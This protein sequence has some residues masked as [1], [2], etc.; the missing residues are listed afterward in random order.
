MSDVGWAAYIVAALLALLFFFFSKRRFDLLTVAYI[1]AIF[2]FLPLLWGRVSQSSRDLTSIVEPEVYVIATLYLLAL[3]FAA[4]LLR[5]IGDAPPGAQPAICLSGWYL[6]LAIVGIVGAFVAS[7]EALIN[8]DK[9]QALKQVGFFYVLF[10]VAASL[11]CISSVVERRWWL[12]A[13]A[14]CLLAIDLL[15]GF[16]VFVTLTALSV[17]LVLLTHLG[18]IRLFKKVPSYGLAA[19]ALV[20]SMLLVHSVR[21]VILG[22]TATKSSEMRGD[23]VQFEDP[24]ADGASH[25]TISTSHSTISKWMSIPLRLLQQSEPFIIQATLVGVVQTDLS[26]RASNIFKS[27]FLLLPP[28]TARL[29]PN[30]FPPTFYDEYQP[31]LYPNITYSTA[32]NIWAEM[33]CRFGRIGVAIFGLLLIV[34]L[35][36]LQRAMLGGFSAWIAPMA[37]GGV[38]VAF[39]MHRNDLHYTL[40]MLRQVG[41]VVAIAYGLS[42]VGGK[43]RLLSFGDAG[44]Q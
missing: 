27:I 6:V 5:R 14:V 31:I 42:V 19:A 36:G 34:M 39:Y 4:V 9:A 16:R 35:V 17:G 28:G 38:I 26:C 15:V 22:D 29:V 25:S 20:M 23:I 24:E 44:K 18:P 1:G 33:L 10:E 21:F 40:V 7:D 11:A 12:L 13:A 8:A 2:Y 37:L 43:L 30:P 32:G 3:V 41:I